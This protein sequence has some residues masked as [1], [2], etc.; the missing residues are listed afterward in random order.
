MAT[1]PK[2][3]RRLATTATRSSVEGTE[4][5]GRLSN[6]LRVVSCGDCLGWLGCL[7]GKVESQP[8]GRQEQ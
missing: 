5:F 1:V 6:N 7:R 2:P 4:R 3:P 8:K